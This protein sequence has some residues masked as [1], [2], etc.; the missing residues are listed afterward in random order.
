[1]CLEAYERWAESIEARV[2]ALKRC[3]RQQLVVRSVEDSYSIHAFLP[4][5]GVTVGQL[6]YYSLLPTS[7]QVP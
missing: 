7:A 5:Y 4:Q 2:T 1:M 3:T 6:A